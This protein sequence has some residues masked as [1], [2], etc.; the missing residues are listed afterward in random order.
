MSKNSP[1]ALAFHILFIIFILTP[2]VVIVLISFTNKG[3]ISLDIT[4]LSFKWYDAIFNNLE[5]ITAFQVSVYLGVLS[6]SLASCMAIPTGLAIAKHQFKGKESINALLLSPLMIP[7][8]VLGIAFIKFFSVLNIA[9]TFL[10]LVLAHTL[11]VMP[12]ALR[13]VLS[14]IYSLD[15]N[16]DNAALSLGADRLKIFM[17]ITFPLIIPGFAS[18]WLISFIQSFDELTMSIFLT[19]AQEVTLP[20]RMYLYIEESI[21]PLILSI[22][23]LVILAVFLLM[24]IID[25]FFGLEKILVGKS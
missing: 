14:V 22:S 25:R 24:L 15:R 18:A 13:L 11:L 3:Y 1:L 8:I 20:V 23:S 21:D 7:H 19:S 9:G 10:G 5:F 2:L 16:L 17:R 4:D 6:A 12:Y